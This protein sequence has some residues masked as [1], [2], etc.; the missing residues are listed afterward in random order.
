MRILSANDVRKAVPMS[1]AIDAVAAGFAQLSAGDATVPLRTRVD[2]P[3]HE[4]VSFFMPA[5]LTGQSTGSA[6]ALGLKAVSVFPHNQARHNAPSIHALVVLL[7]PATGRPIAALDGAYLTALRTGAGSGAA[8]RVMARPDA[9][10]LALFGAGVQARTQA[11]AVCAVR[12]IERIWIVNRTRERAVLLAELLRADGVRAELR[13][14][15]SAAVALDD[16]DIVCC[17][18]SSPTPLFA[19]ADLRP[20]T[21]INGIGSFTHTMAEVPP[22]SVARARVVVDQRAA[23]W[24]E[25]GDL[26]QARDAGLIDETHVVAEL[27]QVILGHI[28]GRIDDTEITFFKSVGNAVQ[29]MSVAQYALSAAIASNLGVEVAL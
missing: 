7:D 2:V 5:Y 19:D 8:T 4:A 13:L 6:P 10:V 15:P 23:A 22:A 14:A 11:L 28:P 29:D 1:A 27:G 25:A 12:P 20:G 18:T 21:H 16:A 9:R 3:Q 26:I 24:A 17:A